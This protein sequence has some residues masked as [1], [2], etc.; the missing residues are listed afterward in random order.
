ML[1]RIADSMFWMNRYL[2]R[3]EGLLRMVLTS[4][5][6]SLDKGSSGGNSWE[7]VLNIFSGLPDDK[8]MMLAKH[9]GNVIKY[10]LLD[11]HN[12]NSLK[13]IVNRARENARGM[14]DHITKEVWEQV[15]HIYHLINSPRTSK[16]LLGGDQLAP[17]ESMLNQCLLYTGVTD[18]TMPRGMGWSFMNLGKFIE[19]CQLT[20]SITS[21][22]F[23]RIGKDDKKQRDI[24][25][26]RGLL[27][28]LSGYELHLKM[29]RSADT[30]KNV[31]DQ[32]IFN[33]QFPHSVLY[34]LERIKKYTEDLIEQNQ[35]DERAA[36]T[37]ALGIL[38]SHI[39]Y[40]DQSSLSGQQL[41]EFLRSIQNNIND[42][43]QQLTHT[44]FS[45]S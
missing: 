34:C 7:P 6:L 35:S 42:Y 2:E 15:N 13:I 3:S 25:Y 11:E 26:W 14:Q 33:R 43:H 10:L 18:S 8:K 20:L 36:L 23:Y 41:Q 29:Y 27:F 5:V 38:I 40:A 39:Q 9:P 12:N 1:S 21:D 32:V 17:M 24:L 19:R 22:H 16:L 30:D 45:Y 4:Y 28:T 37:R 31:L 44:F